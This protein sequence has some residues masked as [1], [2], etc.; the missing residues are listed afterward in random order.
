MVAAASASKDEHPIAEVL[1]TGQERSLFPE[2]SFQ[3]LGGWAIADKEG[4]IAK[5]QT[6]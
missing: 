3:V 4:G 2:R 1:P 6:A 5:A